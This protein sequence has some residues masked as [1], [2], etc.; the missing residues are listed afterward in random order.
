MKA[1]LTILLVLALFAG[2][3]VAADLRV[4]EEFAKIQAAIEAAQNGDRVLIA[5]GLYR[6]RLNFLGKAI[7][8]CGNLEAPE[9]V[10]IK[11]DSAGSLVEFN[12]GEG[13]EA[14]LCGVT[15]RGAT[16]D[17]GGGIYVKDA[18]PTL[19]HLVVDSNKA[20][21]KGGGIFFDGE[22]RAVITDIALSLDSAKYGGGI[23][24]DSGATIT[25]DQLTIFRCYAST[26]G[27][28]IS[29]NINSSLT[30]ANVD[31]K[32]AH[33]KNYGGG[34]HLN[35]S[36]FLD[37]KFF[38]LEG[39][40]TQA[41][42]G[43]IYANTLSS[44]IVQK[45][46][47]VNCYGRW[48]GGGIWMSSKPS[49]V[50]RVLLLGNYAYDYGSAIHSF[51]EAGEEG[52]NL[53]NHL[54]IT[55]HKPVHKVG[56]ESVT[57]FVLYLGRKTHL[58]N[59]IVHGNQ[60]D[61][62]RSWNDALI[63]HTLLSD[64]ANAWKNENLIG[65]GV[66]FGD[67]LFNNAEQN[68]FTLQKESP[69]IDAASLDSPKD[70]DGSYADM[71]VFPHTNL[72]V[73]YGQVHT[74]D[75]VPQPIVGA[76]MKTSLGQ[77]AVTDEWGNYRIT[78][79][80]LKPFSATASMPGF[81]DSTRTGLQLEGDSIR[82]NF[83]LPAPALTANVD[84]LSGELP[85]GEGTNW[86]IELANQGTGP[87]QWQVTPYLNGGWSLEPWAYHYSIPILDN[88]LTAID[89]ITLCRDQ[90]V[91]SARAPGQKIVIVTD[92]ELREIKR[93]PQPNLQGSY[94]GDL[95]TDGELVYGFSGGGNAQFHP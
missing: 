6:D 90:F 95:D 60:S 32:R 45:G 17:Y 61:M 28:G 40:S 8:V 92:R 74:M 15:L 22:C 85:Q 71:G 10:V 55:K 37:L 18:S 73:V 47:I 58:K 66:I 42:G 36:S 93:F 76:T 29:L 75:W 16:T 59:S 20:S 27:G 4:P 35:N 21:Q 12:N 72:G 89:G 3:I 7:T 67:P 23:S 14:V 54:T 49:V 94:L 65:E 46:E 26:G 62:I 9:R 19:H 44:L 52:G 68:N 34:I 41:H 69:A 38:S 48:E 24:C 5:D 53:L 50:E 30:A 70:P 83:Q 77:E 88:N 31:I 11:P 80:S 39:C 13:A 1:L 91:L 51:A 78:G 86:F 87:L 43:G 57:G 84:R 79:V 81:H 25:V 82:V 63:T 2:E 64:P 33:A 56:E